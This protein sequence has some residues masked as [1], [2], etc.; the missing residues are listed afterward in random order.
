MTSTDTRPSATDPDRSSLRLV[1]ADTVVP[2]VTGG[3]RSYVNLDYAASAPALAC[4]ANAVSE[5]L[6][7]YSS[8]HRGT[9]TR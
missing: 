6:E 7:W 8:V 5:L 9:T 1:G 2:L 4:V 3:T